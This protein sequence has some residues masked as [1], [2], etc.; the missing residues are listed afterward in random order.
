MIVAQLKAWRNNDERFKAA[1]SGRPMLE[2]ALP[3][4]AQI[5]SLSEVGLE[6]IAARQSG[7]S[8][9]PAVRRRAGEL[10]T[11]LEQQEAAS[12]LPFAP[13]LNPQ[14]P[15]DLIVKIGPGVSA[16]VAAASGNG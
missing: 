7:R 4:S 12:A 9:D 8:L 16:L 11:K 2:A 6:A 3:T 5:A 10:L 14:P 13:L 1:A 15:A